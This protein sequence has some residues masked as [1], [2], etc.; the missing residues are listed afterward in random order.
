[1]WEIQVLFLTPG[2]KFLFPTLRFGAFY[3]L[4]YTPE[5]LTKKRLF[6]IKSECGKSQFHCQ[7][8][9][10]AKAWVSYIISVSRSLHSL[11]ARLQRTKTLLA[12]TIVVMLSS[13]NQK[14]FCIYLIKFISYCWC[15]NVSWSGMRGAVHLLEKSWVSLLEYSL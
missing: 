4:Q 13:N 12:W 5:F 9:M 15:H 7:F 8:Y 11:T 1:M 3:S 10:M 14:H 2:V 6:G